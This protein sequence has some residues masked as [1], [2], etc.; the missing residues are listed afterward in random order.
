M[1]E[2]GLLWC[3]SWERNSFNHK[4]EEVTCAVDGWM[5]W[6]WLSISNIFQGKSPVWN[7]GDSVY[8]YYTHA[9]ML[10]LAGRWA[11]SYLCVHRITLKLSSFIVPGVAAVGAGARK[12]WVQFSGPLLTYFETSVGHVTA[13]CCLPVCRRRCIA[14]ILLAHG[15]ISS[16]RVCALLWGFSAEGGSTIPSNSQFTCAAK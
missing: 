3:F 8:N 5:L 9:H 11:C 15:G 4:L 10:T 1:P 14:S 7:V 16:S 13:V 2:R 12:P 6:A